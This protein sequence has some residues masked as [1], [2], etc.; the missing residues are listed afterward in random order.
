MYAKG[1]LPAQLA[2]AYAGKF[3]FARYFLYLLYLL[4]FVG[5]TE[6]GVHEC[7]VKEA[8]GFRE[9]RSCRRA[10]QNLTCG[11]VLLH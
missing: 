10:L 8:F 5:L 11:P 9:I 2:P 3:G 7:Q 4:Y 6:R 1:L